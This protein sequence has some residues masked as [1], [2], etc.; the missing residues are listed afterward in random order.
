[1][2]QLIADGVLAIVAGSDTTST[3]FS[4]A[5][6]FLLT[7]PAAYER[8]Q[9]EIDAA[10]PLDEG[11]PFD[12][13]KLAEMPFLNAVINETM[14]LLPPVPSNL[15]RAPAPGSGGKSIGK[16]FIPEGVSI[17]VPP[18]AL[19]RD[20]RYFSSPDE[21]KPER[22]LRSNVPAS[23]NTPAK[24]TSPSEPTPIFNTA[25]F[26]PFSYGPAICAGKNLALMEMRLVIATLMQRY[27]MRLQEGYDPRD[28]EAQLE[29]FFVAK[30][31]KLPVVLTLRS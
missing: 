24:G 5:F 7:H 27:S 28:W 25:A 6:Y 13:T 19:Q 9:A 16:L 23:E 20:P 11:D 10:F 2:K 8:L 30:V 29:D 14:R 15:Q 12:T 31:G 3:V 21:F 18:Y 4:C 17:Q 22:W 26:I 1:M